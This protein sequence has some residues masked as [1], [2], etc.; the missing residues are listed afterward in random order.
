[1][2]VTILRPLEMADAGRARV[3]LPGQAYDLSPVVAQSLI[4]RGEAVLVEPASRD[5][6]A[7]VPIET[8]A[9]RRKRLA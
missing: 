8:G 1:M 4:D 9:R 2:T 7:V 6:A 3:L 5:V